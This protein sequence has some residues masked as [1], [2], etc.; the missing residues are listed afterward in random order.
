MAAGDDPPRSLWLTR[1]L[2]SCV[3]TDACHF[4]P[5]DAGFKGSAWHGRIDNAF[6]RDSY[7]ASA[8]QRSE[9]KSLYW[10]ETPADRTDAPHGPFLRHSYEIGYQF[11][12]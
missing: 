8:F 9:N 11:P 5:E 4:P 7:L 12:L 1:E 2:F 6:R 3:A 10:L